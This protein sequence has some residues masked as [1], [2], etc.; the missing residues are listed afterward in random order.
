MSEQRAI[1]GDQRLHLVGWVT[2][3]GGESLPEPTQFTQTAYALL[4]GAEVTFPAP[5]VVALHLNAAWRSA[6]R[7]EELR[8]AIHWI[9][10]PPSFPSF[11]HKGS[12][13]RAAL[14]ESSTSVL[15]DFMEECIQAVN[16]SFCAL[17]AFC[18]L[19]LVERMNAPRAVKTREGMRD[20]TA[21]EIERNVGTGEKLKRHVPQVMGVPSPAGDSVLWRRYRHLHEVRDELVHFKRANLAS[22]TSKQVLH[23]MAL[24]D[25]FD[26]PE[27]ATVLLTRLHP[28]DRPRWFDPAWKR[29]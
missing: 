13:A 12:P 1:P 5:S 21:E 26:F 23:A 27:T 28:T 14:D 7:A 6:R 11:G 22:P 25:P 17:E 8:S 15:F 29:T 2:T 18:N 16:S 24:C 10:V 4:N 3:I 19:T 20:M 9:R